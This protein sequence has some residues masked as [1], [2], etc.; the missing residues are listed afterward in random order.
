MRQTVS[1]RSVPLLPPDPS[2]V[3]RVRPDL[4]RRGR[5]TGGDVGGR[6]PEKHATQH[7]ERNP[8]LV[9]L[10][11]NQEY[12]LFNYLRGIQLHMLG[13]VL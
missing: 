9:A 3:L 12:T 6:V 1:Q 2:A 10:R 7:L 8:L 5:L 4:L 11:K 13:L